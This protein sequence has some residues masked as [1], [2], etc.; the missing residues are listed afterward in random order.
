[1]NPLTGITEYLAGLEKKLRLL[2]WTRGAA[3]F[4]GAALLTTVLLVLVIH[5]FS[6]SDP[7]VFWAR[8]LLFLVVAAVPDSSHLLHQHGIGLLDGSAGK[9]SRALERTLAQ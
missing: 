1:M 4:G 7:S 3:I 8:V 5:K 9:A 2:A 6:F